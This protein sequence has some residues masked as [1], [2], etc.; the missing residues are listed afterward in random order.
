MPRKQHQYYYIYKTTCTVTGKYYIGMHATSNLNDGYMGSGRRLK[1]SILKYGLLN[2]TKEILEFLTDRQTLINR[3]IELV[4]TDLLKDCM[5]MNLKIGGEGGL[6]FI[7]IENQKN[8][9]RAGGKALAIRLANDSN[10]KQAVHDKLSIVQQRRLTDGTLPTWKNT[11]NW[12]GKTHTDN[13]KDKIGKA[14]SIAQSG[15]RNSQYGTRWMHHEIHGIRKVKNT[16]MQ[17]F[18][19]DGWLI[20]RK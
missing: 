16:D 13:A 8:R 9:S 3:E 7:S 14:N 12:S 11:C 1:Y 5:C 10:L 18:I 17:S 20:G 6:G 15:S 2:H 4:N 19:I